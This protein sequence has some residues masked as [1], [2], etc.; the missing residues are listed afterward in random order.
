MVVCRESVF[1]L[2]IVYAVL[3]KSLYFIGQRY[4]ENN[5]EHTIVMLF[6]FD[7]IFIIDI[8]LLLVLL[9]GACPL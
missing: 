6:I 5:V 1:I 9:S 3:S 2:F 8:P 7:I 4:L